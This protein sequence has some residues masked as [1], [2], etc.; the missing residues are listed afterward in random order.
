MHIEGR[1]TANRNSEGALVIVSSAGHSYRAFIN[2]RDDSNALVFDL[3]GVYCLDGA[4]EVVMD[5]TVSGLSDSI[6]SVR[7]TPSY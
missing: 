2:Q 4:V 3:H 5:S 6:R 7:L 1:H